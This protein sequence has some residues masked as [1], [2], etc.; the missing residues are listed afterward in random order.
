MGDRNRGPRA[1]F[2]GLPLLL[3]MMLMQTIFLPCKM[4]FSSELVL[5]NCKLFESQKQS[6]RAT[7]LQGL[8]EEHL[9]TAY[10]G[11]FMFF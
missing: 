11:K 6:S 4:S 2:V 3:S 9:G 8:L 5:H 10:P 1:L 7:V